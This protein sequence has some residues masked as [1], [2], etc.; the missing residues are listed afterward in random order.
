MRQTYIWKLQ[1]T[2]IALGERTAVMGVLNMTPDSF[3]EGGEYFDRDKAIAHAKEME[4]EGAD[5]IDIGG[6]STRPGSE[7]VAE[8]EEIRRVIPV[9]D[10][11]AASMKI[12][13]SVDTYRAR[14]AQRALDAG[15]QIVNDISGFRLDDELPGVVQRS[16]AAVV[17][18]HSRGSRGYLHKQSRMEKPLQEVME[19]L[20][21]SIDRA[22]VV[23]IRDDA[24]V[25][26]PGIGFGKD[27]SESLTVL[28]NLNDF[29][30]L[31]YSLLVGT[32]RKSFIRLITQDSL[33]ARTWG[34]A[35]TVVAAIMN[36]AH[37]VRVHDVR[38][39]RVLADVTDRLC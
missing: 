27:A 28:K 15:A 32:S 13:I 36:G 4:Q 8:E 35:A 7:P 33:E 16:G 2:T 11:L 23:G 5:I 3:S 29:S 20:A 19:G 24:I 34:T 14:V 6:E 21:A 38:Q 12:P 39:A 18:M 30:K 22:R 1:R 26:D 37:I 10:S 25:I 31:G 9:I 17:L